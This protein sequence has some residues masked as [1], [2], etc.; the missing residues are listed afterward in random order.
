VERSTATGRNP[1]WPQ[2]RR[3]WQLT[4]HCLALVVQVTPWRGVAGMW[5]RL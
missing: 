5:L 3:G 4:P 1:H 2:Y